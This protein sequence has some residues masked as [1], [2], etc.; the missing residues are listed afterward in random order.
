MPGRYPKPIAI[1]I[2]EGNPGH[3]PLK[4][5]S[6]ST[7]LP[8]GAP[9]CPDIVSSDPVAKKCWD[10]HVALLT[11][12]R[13]LTPGDQ[14]TLSNLCVIQSQLFSVLDAVRR[15]NAG[16]SPVLRKPFY[17]P[18]PRMSKNGKPIG[19]P[20]T[21]K[22]EL[23]P[24]RAPYPKTMA[25]GLVIIAHNGCLGI[26]PYVKI[27]RTLMNQELTLC[28]ELGLTPLARMRVGTGN[29]AEAAKNEFDD[30]D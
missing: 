5:K 16:E 20:S 17:K 6:P 14:L 13:V 9:V 30:L 15:M 26:S 27:Q 7:L 18:T 3:R 24:Q 21:V 2:A 23:V 4:P 28:K 29:L 1:R 19:R 22:H 11:Q 8:V 10:D 25:A 12:M